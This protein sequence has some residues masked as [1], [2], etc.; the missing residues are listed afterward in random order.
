MPGSSAGGP[1]PGEHPVPDGGGRGHLPGQVADRFGM[2]VRLPGI[3]AVRIRWHA[4]TIPLA[5]P[6]M[7][8]SGWQRMRIQQRRNIS[9]R[10]PWQGRQPPADGAPIQ[11]TD[12][13]RAGLPPQSRPGLTSPPAT[14][15][16]CVPRPV[17]SRHPGLADADGILLPIPIGGNPVRHAA[18]PRFGRMGHAAAGRVLVSRAAGACHPGESGKEPGH[19]LPRRPAIHQGGTAIQDWPQDGTLQVGCLPEVARGRGAALL[20]K[21]STGGR[22]YI[23]RGRPGPPHD[24][25]AVRR[26][27]PP[28]VG[29]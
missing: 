4:R 29:A 18:G 13:D 21:P 7:T 16:T 19:H 20:G 27:R 25:P 17:G 3:A 11:G 2:V 23:R 6:G 26:G 5:S 9:R 14:S 28:G 12:G 1:L 8:G 24:R 15:R 22:R 10:A